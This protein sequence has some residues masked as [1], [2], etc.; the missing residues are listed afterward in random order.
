M[1][2]GEETTTDFPLLTR[3][4]AHDSVQRK[5]RGQGNMEREKLSDEMRNA[6]EQ[7]IPLLLRSKQINEVA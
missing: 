5:S 7:Q 6:V 3:L 4:L 2:W 1:Q